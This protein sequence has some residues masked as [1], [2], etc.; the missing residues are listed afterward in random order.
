[1]GET[2]AGAG[3]ERE[4]QAEIAAGHGLP[5]AG[6]VFL[7]G[8]CMGVQSR[9][10]HYDT[11]FIPKHKW[12][13]RLEAT[14]RRLAFVSQSGAFLI[15]RLSN[16]GCL[17]PAYAVSV[18]NQI[19]L[20]VAD[21]LEHLADDETLDTYAVYIEGMIDGDGLHLAQVVRR[22]TERRKT[23]VVYRAGR[24]EAGR[25]AT[26]GHTSVLAGDYPVCSAVLS[27]AGALVAGDFRE[28]E[29]LVE[30]STTLHAKQISGQRLGVITNAGFEAVG[31]ADALSG[32]DQPLVLGRLGDGSLATLRRNLGECRLDT[33]VTAGNPLD[34]TPMADEEAYDRCTR[35]MLED[36]QIDAVVVSAVPLTPRLRTIGDELLPGSG[37]A[38]RLAETS[39]HSA[40]PLLIVIDSG[41]LYE[42]LVSEFRRRGLA[43]CR[44][45]DAAVRALGRYFDHRIRLRGADEPVLPLPRA[46]R[47]A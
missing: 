21:V 37:L 31:M 35:V 9:P 16:V 18:G 33:L 25:S 20:T 29:Y 45:A 34:L 4:I 27:R 39:A 32:R 13:P 30:L 3:I 11:F 2:A 14:P 38:Q 28:F 7:G 40:K 41:A 1:M 12:D 5:S 10:G 46:A 47:Q 23:V 6:P 15:T 19:D 8:N 17:D 36:S 24:T 43:V 26:A 44:S 42:P 22:I